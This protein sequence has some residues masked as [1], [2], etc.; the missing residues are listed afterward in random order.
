MVATHG[1]ALAASSSSAP[2]PAVGAADAK[3]QEALE[4]CKTIR[5]RVADGAPV[6]DA[7]A[8]KHK[9]RQQ[10]GMLDK[11]ASRRSLRHL[12]GVPATADGND[13]TTQAPTLDDHEGIS[14]AAHAWRSLQHACKE[15]WGI[16]GEE[17]SE[18]MRRWDQSDVSSTGDYTD[19][20]LKR[21][22]RKLLRL[23]VKQ[24][25]AAY[26]KGTLLRVL[27]LGRLADLLVQLDFDASRLMA[28]HAPV[29][30]HFE[31]SGAYAGV[32][33]TPAEDGVHR[34][35]KT[36]TE[37]NDGRN[38]RRVYIKRGGAVVASFYLAVFVHPGSKKR[39]DT[40][41][42]IEVPAQ[43]LRDLFDGVTH[44]DAL[45]IDAD[46]L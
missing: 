9:L 4:L 19:A 18:L 39:A 43:L 1:R 23:R 33:Y 46:A 30:K 38:I 22:A 45:E 14:A 40:A 15:A 44:M 24:A 20:T 10:R 6:D 37:T 25:E 11:K 17:A 34:C 31:E 8:I 27:W 12:K 41:A 36:L 7:A 29:S 28:S 42:D 3:R 16:D 32:L 21:D 13:P 2:A 5:K 26:K 35:T